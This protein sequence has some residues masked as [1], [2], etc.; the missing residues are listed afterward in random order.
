MG[1]HPLILSFIFG[2]IPVGINHLAKRPMKIKY[3]LFLSIKERYTH[4]DR[5]LSSSKVE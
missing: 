4:T 5:Y 1:L 2:H 3:F